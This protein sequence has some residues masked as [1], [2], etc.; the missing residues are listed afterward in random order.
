[1]KEYGIWSWKNS[2]VVL[3]LLFFLGA[4]VQFPEPILDS[5]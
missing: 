5:P 1:M 3:H 2:F 4:R